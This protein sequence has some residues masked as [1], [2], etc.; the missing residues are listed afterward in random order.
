MSPALS[1]SFCVTI[2]PLLFSPCNRGK[3]FFQLY[4]VLNRH[5]VLLY[6]VTWSY[7]KTHNEFVRGL[8]C[9]CACAVVWL[10]GDTHAEARRMVLQLPDCCSWSSVLVTTVLACLLA[11]LGPR[12]WGAVAQYLAFRR[13]PTDQDGQHWLLGH[14]P[15]VRS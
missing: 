3:G 1:L 4:M 8:F 14:T 2:K 12:L 15:K 11:L 13:V 7:R 6:T 9:E 5:C 10:L